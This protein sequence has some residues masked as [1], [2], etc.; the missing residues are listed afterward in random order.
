MINKLLNRG[1]CYLGEI[2][3][4]APVDI[5]VCDKYALTV[6]EASQ[7][8]SIGEKKLRKMIQ[9]YGENC[10][11]LFFNGVKALIK[12]KKFESFL[13]AVSAI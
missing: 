1:W 11:W 2:S 12:R 4:A 13:D 7:Y 6:E 9:E 3:N 10:N 5:N 8:F